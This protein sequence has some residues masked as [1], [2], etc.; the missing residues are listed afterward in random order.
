MAFT[1]GREAT[2]GSWLR[3]RPRS[4]FGWENKEGVLA[5][6]LCDEHKHK[7]G[8]PMLLEQA[9]VRNVSRAIK[10]INAFEW[11]GDYKPVARQA[12]KELMEKRLEEEMA[13]YLGVCSL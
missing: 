8:T 5:P 7:E 10:E 13:E 11:E 2:I 12:L 1:Y 4:F 9:T 6:E 3:V